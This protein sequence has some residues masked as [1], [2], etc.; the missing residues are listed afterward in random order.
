MAAIATI[1]LTSSGCSAQSGHDRAMRAFYAIDSDALNSSVLREADV[2]VGIASA[3]A[4]SDPWVEIAQSRLVLE[5]GYRSGARSRLQSFE[6]EAVRQALEH[7][8]RAVALGPNESM[9]HV[10]LARL[11]IITGELQN[12][13]EQLNQAHDLDPQGFY[14]WY[15]RSV[16]A[17]LMHD[18]RRSK[19]AL[20]EAEGHATQAYQY[21][22][23]TEA[24]TSLAA[25][26]GD[27]VAEEAA[28]R[29]EIELNP[30]D[31]YAYGNYAVF[32][33]R[34]RRYDE[35]IAYYRKAISLKPYSLAQDQLEQTLLQKEAA[36][37]GG[38]PAAKPSE[39]LPEL[40]PPAADIRPMRRT[41]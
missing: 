25:S 17:R 16:I 14:P 37:H 11:L 34:E 7:A 32:L 18:P 38:P 39:P 29:R 24:R 40:K 10:Q 26:T 5:H 23:V 21:R 4:K 36:A 8:R 15:Y 28:H 27:K 41:L 35:A 13:W 19:D 30:S 22:W 31:A 20:D 3:Q 12:A 9:S 1:V 2:A 6:P 33:K